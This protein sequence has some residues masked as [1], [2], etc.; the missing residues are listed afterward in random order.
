MRNPPKSITSLAL[1]MLKLH[2]NDFGDLSSY[3]FNYYQLLVDKSAVVQLLITANFRTRN[4]NTQAAKHCM[5][6]VAS[7]SIAVVIKMQI[8]WQSIAKIICST[9]IY[10]I[11]CV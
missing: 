6:S 10:C 3:L 8:F 1:E 11:R 5:F 4:F 2:T 9:N 7:E